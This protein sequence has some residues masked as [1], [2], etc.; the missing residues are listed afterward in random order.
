[1]RK[2]Y[3]IRHAQAETEF[4]SLADFDRQLTQ[5]GISQAAHTGSAIAKTG[6]SFDLIISSTAAR[7]LQTAQI[8][9]DKTGYATNQII[10]EPEL[11]RSSFRLW[12]RIIHGI[13]AII[14]HIAVVGHNPEISHVL[15]LL[16]RKEGVS[17]PVGSAAILEVPAPH[18]WDAAG[19]GLLVLHEF[20]DP[21]LLMN[22]S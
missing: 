11:Y 19:P 10:K 20:I 21:D 17:M 7:A 14:E 9:A 16:T 3:I 2:I 1:M 22:R 15:E 12:M 18:N 8:I 5:A 6:I 4:A 13:P